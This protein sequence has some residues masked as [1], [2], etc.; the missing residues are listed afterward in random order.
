MGKMV[1]VA[2]V[3]GSLAFVSVYVVMN[4]VIGSG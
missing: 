4:H 3:M 2:A 1:A